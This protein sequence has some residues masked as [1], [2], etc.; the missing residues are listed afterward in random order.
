MAKVFFQRIKATFRE[1]YK[2][3]WQ[4]EKF[5][6][7]SLRHVFIEFQMSK[8]LLKAANSNALRDRHA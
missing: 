2:K 6:Q 3:V 8:I 4:G 7:K 1:K 5:C